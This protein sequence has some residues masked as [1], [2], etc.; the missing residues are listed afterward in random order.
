MEPDA[1]IA[2]FQKT[3]SA[4]NDA[5]IA[6]QGVERRAR[7]RREGQY[8][9]DLI[10]DE[11]ALRVLAGRHLTVVSEESGVSEGSD[12]DVIIVM[13]PIDGSSNAVRDIPYWAT[14]LCAMDRSGPLA[15]LVVNQA[16][17]CSWTAVRGDGARREGER[18]HVSTVE[19][20][21]DAV[22]ALSTFPSRVL[23][24]K[25]FRAFGSCAL[26]LCDVACGALDGYV[27]GGSIH[28]PWDYLA[29]VLIC[30]EAGATVADVG[31]RPLAVA[32][33]SA[34]RQLLCAATPMLADGLRAAIV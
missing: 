14:A 19:R 27:D 13:D 22:V 4:I 29:S 18:I 25:Q 17:G 11:A 24:W 30:Q 20:V 6:V 16:T 10:A 9:I 1:L 28:A 32:D 5:L 12:G 31:G 33:P 21:E 8:A 26:A 3:A 15:A 7:T 2:L 23:A 34:R